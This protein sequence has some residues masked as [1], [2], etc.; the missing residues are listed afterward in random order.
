[1]QTTF[2]PRIGPHSATCTQKRNFRN[3]W[4]ETNA[5]YGVREPKLLEM[6][7]NMEREIRF[8]LRMSQDEQENLMRD[9][10]IAYSAERVMGMLLAAAH[11]L[12]GLTPHQFHERRRRDATFGDDDQESHLVRTGS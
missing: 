3:R 4:L 9:T 12:C 6:L 11:G 1:M 2:P 10:R 5:T 7:V 8:I